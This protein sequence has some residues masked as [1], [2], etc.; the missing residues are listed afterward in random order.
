[1]SKEAWENRQQR[2]LRSRRY[3]RLMYATPGKAGEG[4]CVAPSEGAR[5]EGSE[6]GFGEARLFQFVG[7]E[8]KG[9][10][11]GG[12]RFGALGRAER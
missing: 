9:R 11:E 2:L 6:E 3:Q 5:R 1:M 8:K 7:R 12:V 10:G 4:N